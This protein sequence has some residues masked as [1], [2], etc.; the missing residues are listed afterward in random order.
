MWSIHYA[1]KFMAAAA[2]V[3]SGGDGDSDGSDKK[4]FPSQAKENVHVD[5]SDGLCQALRK[6]TQNPQK[7]PIVG[8]NVVRIKT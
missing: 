2:A 7:H 1:L 3:A 5:S 4:P 6:T 8:W